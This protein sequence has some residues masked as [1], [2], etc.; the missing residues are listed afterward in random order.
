MTTK[1]AIMRM[2]NLSNKHTLVT[3]PVGFHIDTFHANL[4][5]L[6]NKVCF[7]HPR[8]NGTD[9]RGGAGSG[10]FVFAL[11]DWGNNSKNRRRVY[12]DGGG[13]GRFGNQCT[14]T[15]WEAFCALFGRDPTNVD[16]LE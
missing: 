11:L 16:G 1:E 14:Q 10:A 8:I 7:I 5:S 15:R 6:E 3:H 13:V 2:Y 9:G 12:V 4:P